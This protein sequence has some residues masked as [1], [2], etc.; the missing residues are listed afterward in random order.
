M[1]TRKGDKA[2]VT[3]AAGRWDVEN[4]GRVDLEKSAAALRTCDNFLV[5]QYGSLKRRPGTQ[6][7]APLKGFDDVLNT[8]DNDPF[9]LEADND[10]NDIGF[11]SDG[12]FVIVGDFTVV[13]STA[14]NAVS[15]H[16]ADGSLK[17]IDSPMV[18]N[19]T[20]QGLVMIDDDPVNGWFVVV[21]AF[22]EMGGVTRKGAAAINADGTH[23]TS[24]GDPDF[25]VSGGQ[26]RCVYLTADNKLLIGGSFADV[27]GAANT[28]RLTRLEL[29]GTRD[30]SF[31][32][33]ADGSVHR[34]VLQSNGKWVIAG[35]FF[36]VTGT[37]RRSFARLNDDGTVDTSFVLDAGTTHSAYAI[38]KD[39]SDRLYVGIEQGTISNVGG[40][41]LHRLDADG[42]HDAT[43]APAVGDTSVNTAV[44]DIAV[45]GDGN[46][47]F[48]G[49][50]EGPVGTVPGGGFGC[51][52]EAGVFPAGWGGGSG[53]VGI[54]AAGAGNFVYR[55]VKRIRNVVYVTG[56]FTTIN[57]ESR[58]RIA[59]VKGSDGSV[60]PNS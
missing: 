56:R 39:S 38:A 15:F 14:R 22:S 7:M 16:N 8:D 37:S 5:E 58:T 35:E 52:T 26:P 33:Y 27:G 60:H 41:K 12:S 55:V 43:F 11:F 57:G 34:A 25:N 44:F 49:S 20:I 31:V 1:G 46:I 40:S 6:F 48:G 36:T 24:F 17:A 21:G 18:I 9:L 2:L 54:D 4:G 42:S 28:G 53:V 29:D 32:G 47:Y 30:T 13:N 45:G 59:K 23:R 50:Y 51:V 10:V 19:S 3:F